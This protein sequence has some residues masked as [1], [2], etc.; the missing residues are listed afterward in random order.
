[1][2]RWGG[3]LLVDVGREVVLLESKRSSGAKSTEKRSL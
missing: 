1:M 3:D 2:R